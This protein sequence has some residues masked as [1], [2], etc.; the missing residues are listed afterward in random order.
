MR[1]SCPYCGG[2]ARLADGVELFPQREELAGRKFW[3]CDPCDAHVGTHTFDNERPLGR[4]A[5]AELRRWKARA[6]RAF[7]P[8]WKKLGA[9]YSR[10]QAYRALAKRM[11]VTR[12][13]C[14]I[15]LF[16]VEQCR[17]VVEIV[18]EGEI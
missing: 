11:K 9:R 14:H 13:C 17:R 2:Q 18:K 7:D 10:T 6:H 5:N 12:R 15:G 4:L 3:R 16:D 8:L 1:V